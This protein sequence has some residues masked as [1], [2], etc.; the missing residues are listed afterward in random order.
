M[1]ANTT[2]KLIFGMLFFIFS[3]ID[4]QFKQRALTW[5]FYTID[6]TLPTT[7][8]VELVNKK[9]FTK[10]ALDENC[11]TFGVYVTFLNLALRISSDKKA[12]IAFLLTKEVK[13]PDKYSDF[14]D[15]FSKKKALILSEWNKL[16]EHTIN[17]ENG[18]QLP[19]RPIY[20]L[21]LVKLETLKTYIETHL[22]TGFIQSFKFAM[23]TLI[24][25]D[26]KPDNSLRLCVDYQGFNNLTIKN[27][28][29]QLLIGES[30]N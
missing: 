19:Y 29:S 1:L 13:I 18:K 23:G 17:L 21:G 8:W 27:R 4:I 22:K 16:N 11:K 14:I 12:Q 30:L 9:E 15:I 28:C 25:F 2:L 3:N 10:V 6:K 24:L 7:K 5:K 26:K 20:S